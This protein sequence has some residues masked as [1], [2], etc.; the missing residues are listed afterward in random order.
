V[1]RMAPMHYELRVVSVLDIIFNDIFI[2]IA[3]F[4]GIHGLERIIFEP[5]LVAGRPSHRN[6]DSRSTKVAPS[7]TS[8]CMKHWQRG[9]FI[10]LLLLLL[11]ETA[12]IASGG[13]RRFAGLSRHFSPFRFDRNIGCLYS[14][15]W[16]EQAANVS[17][18]KNWKAQHIHM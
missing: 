18:I 13:L 5:L 11:M 12:R 3:F 10:S 4:S 7:L 1:K 2:V 8:Y 16:S 9:G 14:V 17:D 6:N 15:E